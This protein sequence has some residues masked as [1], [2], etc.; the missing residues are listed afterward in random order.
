MPE[1]ALCNDIDPPPPG[2][3]PAQRGLV[4]I[5]EVPQQCEDRATADPDFCDDIWDDVDECELNPERYDDI[6]P[7][8]E[9]EEEAAADEDEEQV[10]E[11]VDDSVENNSNGGGV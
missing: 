10:E 1:P 7:V 4:P 3:G 2:C 11:P 5:A 6:P 8:E 9:E